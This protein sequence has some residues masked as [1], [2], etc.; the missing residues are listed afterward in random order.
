MRIFGSTAFGSDFGEF[1]RVEA[2]ARRE[3]A[4]VRER[5]REIEG[6]CRICD[7]LRNDDQF[8]NKQEREDERE[9]V[10]APFFPRQLNAWLRSHRA[11]VLG[12]IVAVAILL[13]VGYFLQ[14]NRGP[15]LW[16]HRWEETDMNFFHQ[17]ACDIAAGDWLSNQVLHPL[18]DWHRRVAVQYF[19]EHTDIL[20]SLTPHPQLTGSDDV[21]VRALWNLWYG[22]KRFHQEPL[23]PYLIAV[24]IKFFGSAVQWVFVSQLLLGVLSNVLVYLIGRRLFGELVAVTAAT[25]ASLCGMLLFYEMVLL[26]A[27]LIN[28]MGLLLVYLFI[29]ADTKKTW[30]S[31][32]AAG[33][34]GG[35]ALLLKMTFSLFL[36]AALLVLAVKYRRQGKLL[37][38]AVGMLAA[39]TAI[40]M[41]ATVGRN[42]AV[43]APPLGL[44]S[45][46]AVTFI[47]YNTS[48][49]PLTS[50]FHVSMNYTPR[51]MG[52]TQG[53]FLPAVVET[54]KTYDRPGDYIKKLWGKFVK[55]W[56]WYEI[57]NNV[58]FYYYRLHS[59][60]LS[61][62]PI[63]FLIL[64]P[65]GLVGMLAGLKY[66]RTSWPLY[67]LAASLI[68]SIL[69][70]FVLSRFRLPLAGLFTIFAALALVRTGEWFYNKRFIWG[71]LA[72]A[73]AVLAGLWTALPLPEHAVRIRPLD[74]LAAYKVYYIPAAQQAQQEN[75]WP[76]A[77][78]I[79]EDSFRFEPQILGQLSRQQPVKTPEEF[80]LADFYSRAYMFCANDLR[81]LDRVEDARRLEQR[82]D[83]LKEAITGR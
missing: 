47:T 53:R 65:L 58:N 2:L 16:L 59:S 35:L 1:S 41:A 22:G 4:E 49:Y 50:T 79:W 69:F 60:I 29:A 39:G 3:L 34:A 33:L 25:L 27:T 14:I 43:G 72:V 61:F 9:I 70:T 36:G 74:Y 26:R 13:R 76:R 15:C 11:V 55:I 51:I 71:L 24:F 45:V 48:D 81:Q 10:S 63:T 64:G 62:L 6:H 21:A 32:L 42:L 66:L 75:N 30:S 73:G 18:H 19:R 54:L 17:W 12:V 68:A 46:D 80:K 77:V 28:F 31:W 78:Q 23:Y 5:L 44:T 67:V 38:T 8:I 20:A 40:S 52:Q 37:L 82:A 57:P 56:N 83:E 7:Q